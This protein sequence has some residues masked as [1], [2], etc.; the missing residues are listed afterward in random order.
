M[1]MVLS[2]GG[3]LSGFLAPKD[4]TMSEANYQQLV[5]DFRSVV[6]QPDAA[7]RLQVLRA[8]VDFTP[9]TMTPAELHIRDLMNGSRD[10]LLGLWGV[11]LSQIGGSN[12]AGLNSGD[13]RKYD[14]AALWQ[15]ANHPRIVGFT[16]T[17]QGLLDRYVEAG[18][19]VELEIDEP[20][21]DDD[22]PRYD[23]LFKSIS[24]PLRNRERRAL[25]GLDPFG[26][27]VMGASGLPLDDEVWLPVTIVSAMQ[28]PEPNETIIN[29]TAQALGRAVT[30]NT[31]A[32]DAAGETGDANGITKARLSPKVAPLHASLVKLRG[33]IERT[34]T[35]RLRGAVGAVLAAQRAEIAAR[36]RS[37]ADAVTRNPADTTVWFVDGKWDKALGAA[38]KPHLAG[39]ATSVNEHIA[40]VIA[41]IEAKAAPIGAVE[42]VMARGAARVTK[43][44][45]TT[46]AKVQEAIARALEEGMTA[47]DAADIVE[48]IG[49]TTLGG[50]DLA[51]LFDPYRA[52]MIARTELMDA[53]N[54]TALASYGDGGITEVQAIDGDNDDECAARDGQTFSMDE[55]DAIEDHPNGT[56]DW[57][58]VIA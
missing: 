40:S 33:N 50:L 28:A 15:N 22:S 6:E 21:F 45:E 46:R 37:H 16:E 5:A 32:G 56:L 10:D 1:A 55:A 27:D 8:P 51:S 35:P 30:N 31:A 3:R 58:P 39:M 4:G 25:V 49:G 41:P 19:I 42:R 7:K 9:T 13:T 23:L 53:Y 44:N 57:V 12:P 11:P 47:N 14:E 48:G 2:S 24:T 38:L 29:P 26:A 52:E 43:I 20:E 17:V 18:A 54:A 36:I 34:A